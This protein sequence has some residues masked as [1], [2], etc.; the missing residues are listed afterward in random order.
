M[1]LPF[2]SPDERAS[3]NIN[4]FNKHLFITYALG[5]ILDPGNKNIIEIT[6]FFGGDWGVSQ[7]SLD[8]KMVL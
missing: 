6:L 3:C 2:E 4:A 8:C 5:T 7:Q 1:T